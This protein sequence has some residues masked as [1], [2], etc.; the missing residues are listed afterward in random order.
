MTEYDVSL[1]KAVLQRGLEE[2]YYYANVTFGN[3]GELNDI[4]KHNVDMIEYAL[5]HPDISY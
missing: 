5:A 2:I 4:E 3:R 1:R